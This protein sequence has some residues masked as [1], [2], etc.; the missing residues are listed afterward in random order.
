MTLNAVPHQGPPLGKEHQTSIYMRARISRVRNLSQRADATP[1]AR[2]LHRRSPTVPSLA[3]CNRHHRGASSGHAC[4]LA[5]FVGFPCLTTYSGAIA[6]FSLFYHA[7]IAGKAVVL[8][9]VVVRTSVCSLD[10][11]DPKAQLRA[12]SRLLRE[13]RF[14]P[15]RHP[16]R[17]RWIRTNLE[18]PWFLSAYHVVV[19]RLDRRF[20]LPALACHRRVRGVTPTRLPY[21]ARSALRSVTTASLCNPAALADPPILPCIGVRRHA[22]HPCRKPHKSEDLNCPGSFQPTTSFSRSRPCVARSG[23]FF[24]P[25]LL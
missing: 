1:R 16:C 2:P 12:A 5:R 22:A 9:L 7:V 3:G 20:G 6:C 23:G 11:G 13:A 25:I 19:L 8:G 15:L 17:K 21:L 14:V 18:L 4:R 24:Q 10:D